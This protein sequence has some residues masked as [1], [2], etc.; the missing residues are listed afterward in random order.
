VILGV[1][2]NDHPLPVYLAAGVPVVI[3]TDDAGV[4]R[5]HMTKNISVP[6]A[7]TASTIGR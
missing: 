4:S 6:R 5:I 3:S 1:R 2:G 7:T